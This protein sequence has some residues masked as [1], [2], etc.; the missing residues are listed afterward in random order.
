MAASMAKVFASEVAMRTAI[1]AVQVHGGYGY[2]KEY[3]VERL[4][5]DAKITQIYEGTSEIQRL[6]I[7]RNIT[8]GRLYADL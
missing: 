5:R 1:E 3:H 4:M 2:V 7:A 6:V 8:K